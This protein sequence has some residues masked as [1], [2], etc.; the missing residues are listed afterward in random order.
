MKGLL[1]CAG[2][3]III[4]CSSI[5]INIED[6]YAT[7]INE[8]AEIGRNSE[9]YNKTVGLFGGSYACI[10][11][12]CVV[13]DA[14]QK[15]FNFELKNYSRGGNGFSQDRA[16][17]QDQAQ[18]C[19]KADFYIIWASTNDIRHNILCGSP[20]DYSE[21][22]DYNQDKLSTQCGGINKVIQ[23]LKEKNP[24]A[25]IVFISS[26]PFFE[27][28]NGYDPTYT[29]DKI[30]MADFVLGQKQVC[31]L[32][33]VPFI[34]LFEC[35]VFTL[36]NSSVYYQN[37]LIHLSEEGYKIIA[38]ETIPFFIELLNHKFN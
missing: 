20:Y 4:S 24:N 29:D 5:D 2:L 38:L 34:N 26:C 36:E 33:K 7:K 28:I 32:N 31:Q 1:F 15:V 14:W 37:D 35:N 3:F 16:S 23:I 17:I 12:C 21:Y 9:L 13:L 25:L 19:D 27:M 30:N 10:K 8:L 18:N 11:E 22:D 6:E